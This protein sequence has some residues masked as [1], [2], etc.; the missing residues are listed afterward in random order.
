MSI[1]SVFS[2]KG[3][4]PKL[5]MVGT[6][7]LQHALPWVLFP[8]PLFHASQEDTPRK[9]SSIGTQHLSLPMAYETPFLRSLKRNYLGT[10]QRKETS[11]GMQQT[12][13]VARRGYHQIRP[14]SVHRE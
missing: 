4:Q 10:E 7:K 12:F 8:L 1:F 3:E 11:I 5:Q 13:K 2:I 6:Y 9:Q 14:R